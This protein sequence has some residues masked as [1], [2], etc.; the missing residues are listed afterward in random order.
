MTSTTT[1]DIERIERSV[2]AERSRAATAMVMVFVWGVIAV[3]NFVAAFTTAYTI[4]ILAVFNLVGFILLVV[5]TAIKLKTLVVAK[6]KHAELVAELTRLRTLYD[7]G[8]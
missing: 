5:A 1:V 3:L 4:P 6:L 8:Y 2:E 7:K